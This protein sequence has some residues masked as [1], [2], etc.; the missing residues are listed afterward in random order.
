MW[1]IIAGENTGCLRCRTRIRTLWIINISSAWIIALIPTRW[2]TIAKYTCTRTGN[3]LHAD[4]HERVFT[5]PQ[6]HH[7]RSQANKHIVGVASLHRQTI[8]TFISPP[9]VKG[10]YPRTRTSL[11]TQDLWMRRQRSAFLSV[12]ASTPRCAGT[13]SMPGL[14]SLLVGRQRCAGCIYEM[15]HCSNGQPLSEHGH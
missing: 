6:K 8:R 9:S 5:I 10:D 1:A 15:P 2:H 7:P 12:I 11:C 4:L 14:S 13:P 3:A